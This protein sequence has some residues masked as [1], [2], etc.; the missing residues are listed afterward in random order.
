MM[1]A[2]VG[3][4]AGFA[5]LGAAVLLS[6][7]SVRFAVAGMLF[8]IEERTPTLA[9]AAGVGQPPPKPP[10][11]PPEKGGP[12]VPS[13]TALRMPVVVNSPENRAEV[14][15]GGSSVGHT[16]YLGEVSCKAGEPIKI[17]VLPKKGLPRSYERRCAPGGIQLGP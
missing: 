15:I 6:V 4:A 5:Q 11:K 2:S 1:R 13:G 16:P 17:D 7:V 14:L 9:S 12:T 8:A 3:R 10:A